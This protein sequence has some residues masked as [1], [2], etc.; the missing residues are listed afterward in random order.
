MA[1]PNK[2]RVI[3]VAN[4]REK[5]IALYLM[6]LPNYEIA[7]RLGFPEGKS[8]MAGQIMVG[9]D[10]EAYQQ[11]LKESPLM[12][13]AEFKA[14]QL[15][16]LRQLQSESYEAYK[17]SI[18]G[19]NTTKDYELLGKIKEELEGKPKGKKGK[20]PTSKDLEV[21]KKEHEEIIESGV[22]DVA[23]LQFS[24]QCIKD[25]NEL[26]GITGVPLQDSTSPPIIK[27]TVTQSTNNQPTIEVEAQQVPSLPFKVQ[28]TEEQPVQEQPN[29]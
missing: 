19:K 8:G 26:M 12:D 24:R 21:L 13:L 22:G 5:V 29:E 16:K 27:F 6:G 15:A 7:N 23:F 11:Q 28:S 17:R 9:K 18:D 20:K 14:Q 4:R 1:R 3:E 25:E 10:I 2:I